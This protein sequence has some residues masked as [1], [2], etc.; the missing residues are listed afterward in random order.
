[1]VTGGIIQSDMYSC[2]E[3]TC[4]LCNIM[5]LCIHPMKQPNRYCPSCEPVSAGLTHRELESG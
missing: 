4:L 2:E 5:L 1:M 3:Q